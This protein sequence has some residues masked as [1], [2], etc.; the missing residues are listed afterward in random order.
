[1]SQASSAYIMKSNPRYDPGWVHK[2]VCL[3]LEKFEQEV[4][5]GN[6]PRL[7]ITFPPRHGKLL[8]DSTPVLT[9]TGWKQH[10]ELSVGD[11]VFSPSG[12]PVKVTAISP[13]HFATHTVETFAGD[14][15]KCHLDHEWTVFDRS[16]RKFRTLETRDMLT[17]EYLSGGRARFQLPL[18]KP[19]EFA[20][21][22]LEVHP[23]TLGAWLGDGSAGQTLHYPSP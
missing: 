20:E 7:M 12:E 2:D 14:K 11:Y 18:I 10:G 9:T 8:A 5:A 15:I 19:V 21:Q 6:S 17:S 3:R 4:V 16:R 13:K 1:M 23:Y 22:E